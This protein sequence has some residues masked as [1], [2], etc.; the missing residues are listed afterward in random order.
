MRADV[1]DHGVGADR[2]GRVHRRAERGDALL[3]EVVLRAREVE[4]IERMDGDRADSQL[5]APRAEGLEVGRVV[6]GKAPG[7]SAL[8][9]QLHGV[10]AEAMRVVERLPDSTRA[11]AAEEHATTIT[12]WLSASAAR[13]ARPAT[14]QRAGTA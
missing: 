8:H 6:L 7:A 10:H 2:A 14:R 5:L 9:E 12:T 11:V 13:R 1:E 3:V 4:Q